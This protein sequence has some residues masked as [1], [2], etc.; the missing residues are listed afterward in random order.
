MNKKK[1]LGIMLTAAAFLMTSSG[2]AYADGWWHQRAKEQSATNW[3]VI[4]NAPGQCANTPCTE[5][6][7]FGSAGV[8]GVDNNPTKATVC[9]LTGQV[10]EKNGSATFAGAMGEGDSSQCFFPGF[11]DADPHALKDSM[12]AEIHL[13]IQVHGEPLELGYGKE[14]QLTRAGQGCNPDAT[15]CADV[16]FAIHMPGDA[17]DGV[18]TTS[19]NRF[20]DGTAVYGAKSMLIR[21]REG[22]RVIT[23]TTLDKIY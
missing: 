13:I 11:D 3:L 17:V 5:G 16:Q 1:Y 12:V 4:V 22:V 23:M 15:A 2:S 9:Y 18:T 7:I 21:D 19:V 14:T 10:V 20:D 6:D 8:E